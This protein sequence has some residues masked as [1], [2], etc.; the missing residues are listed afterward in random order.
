MFQKNSKERA[1]AV[2]EKTIEAVRDYMLADI[3]KYGASSVKY[4]WTKQSGET[5]SL[6]LTVESPEK[7]NDDGKTKAD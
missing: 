3:K 4:Q 6:E 5:V 2:T 1:A 7:E